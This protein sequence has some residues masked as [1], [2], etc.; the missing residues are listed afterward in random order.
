M[1]TIVFLSKQGLSFRG[2]RG[3]DDSENRSNCIA[4]QI[5]RNKIF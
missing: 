3:N 2:Y 5:F 4:Q 1:R